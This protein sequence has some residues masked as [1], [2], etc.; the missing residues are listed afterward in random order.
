MGTEIKMPQLG[1]TVVEGT[2]TKWLKQEGDQVA[3]DDLLVEI[4]TDK[5]D[6]EVPSSASGT[7]QKILVQEGDTVKVGTALAIIG[8]GSAAATTDE[9]PEDRRGPPTPERTRP[10]PRRAH[11][12]SPR[13]SRT[14]TLPLQQ[15]DSQASEGSE[16]EAP[17]ADQKVA[18]GSNGRSQA[19]DVPTEE[20]AHAGASAPAAS[21]RPGDISKRGIISPLVRRL[22][23][24]HGI[25]L[26]E[27]EG[28]VPGGA[29]A[30]KTFLDPSRKERRGRPR[31]ASSAEPAPAPEPQRQPEQAPAPAAAARVRGSARSSSHGRTS[32]GAR[33]STWLLPRSRAPVHG[34]RWR[35][36]GPTS[37]RCGRG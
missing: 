24:E 9:A 6:S 34:T 13:A 37:R 17:S 18:S 19:P 10:R 4:S 27:L 5:V 12:P 14:P 11:R 25:D 2:I 26:A 31:S 36:T 23:D 16:T 28:P 30:S 7:L 32:G 22:A 8:E 21:G 3:A 33:P 35:R 29:S 20:P 15:L 1:E